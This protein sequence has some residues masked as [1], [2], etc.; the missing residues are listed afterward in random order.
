MVDIRVYRST[1][2]LSP[3]I[4]YLHGGGWVTG[5]I[6]THDA[7]CRS[8]ALATGCAV[9][10]VDYRLAP[11][12]PYPAAVADATEVT[13]WVCRHASNLNIDAS[14]LAVAGDS[15]G[16]NLAMAVSLLAAGSKD[17]QISMQILVLSNNHY[18]SQSLLRQL[19]R[20]SCAL[21]R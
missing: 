13:F 8:L 12:H 19:V 11:E 4:V 21:A 1:D 6:A 3:L 17:L 10:S 9:V 14:R 18:R 2:Q 20:H 5:S 7:V 15:A 16:A